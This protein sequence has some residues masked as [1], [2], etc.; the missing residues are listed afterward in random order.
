MLE[1]QGIRWGYVFLRAA[2]YMEAEDVKR[3]MTQ[4]VEM[5]L[6]GEDRRNIKSSTC[7]GSLYTE[8]K[9]ELLGEFGGQRF[10]A[11]LETIYGR[12]KAAFLVS[13]QTRTA[14]P[15]VSLN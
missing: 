2:S 3:L 11:E 8:G 9:Y 4:A 6:H 15:A 12:D 7:E 13:E 10:D 5:Y 1:H 14:G